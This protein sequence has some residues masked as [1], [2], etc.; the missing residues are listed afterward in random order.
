MSN[1]ARKERV[2]SVKADNGEHQP[3]SKEDAERAEI[4]TDEMESDPG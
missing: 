3:A 4:E 1:E 2:E